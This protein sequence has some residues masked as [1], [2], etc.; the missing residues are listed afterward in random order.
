M[1]IGHFEAELSRVALRQK[2]QSTE[3][4]S[5]VKQPAQGFRRGN[6][7]DTS[8]PRNG[9]ITKGIMGWVER[10]IVTFLQNETRLVTKPGA[11]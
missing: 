8:R 2:W 5:E 11:G 10:F 7:H 9:W 1:R 3:N 6:F 4:K